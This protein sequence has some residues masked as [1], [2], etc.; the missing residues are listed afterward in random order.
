MPVSCLISLPETT[1]DLLGSIGDKLAFG[2]TD[3]PNSDTIL[4][5]RNIDQLS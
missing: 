4:T 2:L 3:S 1:I 5:A